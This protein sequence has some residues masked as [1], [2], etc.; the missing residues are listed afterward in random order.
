M[1][2]VVVATAFDLYA[3][4]VEFD[5]LDRLEEAQAGEGVSQALIDEADASDSRRQQAAIANLAG[6]VVGGLILLAWVNRTNHACRELGATGMQFSPGWAVGYWF[7]PFVNLVRPYQVM[8]ELWGQSDPDDASGFSTSPWI[9]WWWGTWLVSGFIERIGRGVFSESSNSIEALRS[10]DQLSSFASVVQLISIALTI[11]V[12][13]RITRRLALR[14]DRMAVPS[15][16]LVAES[17]V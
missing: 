10:A 16:R 17:A 11:V 5:L 9:G 4:V 7:I 6:L 13:A 12:V 1:W 8:Q 2:L 3:T 14:R 15:A